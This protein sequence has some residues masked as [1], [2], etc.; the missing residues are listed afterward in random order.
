MSELKGFLLILLAIWVIWFMLGG[1]QHD[2]AKA[3]PFI[4]PAAP[5]DNGQIYGPRTQP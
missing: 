5:I 1:A 2:S 4:E 3:G